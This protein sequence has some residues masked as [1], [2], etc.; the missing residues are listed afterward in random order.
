MVKKKTET[1]VKQVVEKRERNS[2]TYMLCP[3]PA[4]WSRTVESMVFTL[5]GLLKWRA[6]HDNC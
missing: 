4:R 6:S 2:D 1:E 3:V 5:F